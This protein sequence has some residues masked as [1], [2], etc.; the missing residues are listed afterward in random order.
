VGPDADRG[1]V[2]PDMWV[3][4][5]TELTYDSLIVMLLLAPERD[6]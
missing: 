3:P 2:R 5:V 6:R 1:E 4:A